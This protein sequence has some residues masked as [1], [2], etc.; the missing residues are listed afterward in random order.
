MQGWIIRIAIVAVIVI[1]GLIFRDRLSGSAGDLK[2][3][4]CFDDPQG[5]TTVKDVQHH[6]CNETHTSEVVFVGDVPGESS[7][8][9]GDAG[10]VS[11]AVSNCTPAFAAYTGVDIAAQEV[12]DMSYLD[13]KSVV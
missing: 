5:V 3:G 6:P 11:W 13:R 12:L 2:V 7:T 9:P 1:G 8:Y 4:D 10:F